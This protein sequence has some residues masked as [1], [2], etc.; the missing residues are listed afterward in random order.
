VNPKSSRNHQLDNSIFWSKLV[1]S[2]GQ[3]HLVT[4]QIAKEWLEQ[5]FGE[6]VVSIKQVE[7]EI[8]L[9][10]CLHLGDLADEVQ[11]R[12]LNQAHRCLQNA[13]SY[14]AK[15]LC[16]RLFEKH[17]KYQL[18]EYTSSDDLIMRIVDG[19]GNV[20]DSSLLA[21]ILKDFKP[22]QSCLAQRSYTIIK[23]YLQDEGVLDFSSDWKNLC[24]ITTNQLIRI[25]EYYQLTPDEVEYRCDIH[26]AFLSVYHE[27]RRRY[28]EDRVVRG[29]RKS[30]K[31]MPDPTDEQ[32]DRILDLIRQ[33]QDCLRHLPK[34]I[35]DLLKSYEQNKIDLKRLL[36]EKLKETSNLVRYKDND[37]FVNSFSHSRY[38]DKSG[39]ESRSTLQPASSSSPTLKDDPDV[40][41]L[42]LRSTRQAIQSILSRRLSCQSTGEKSHLCMRV[43]QLIYCENLSLEEIPGF[44]EERL[45]ESAN[46]WLRDQPSITRF[47]HKFF[48]LGTQRRQQEGQ[49]CNKGN[50]KKCF[51]TE[52]VYEVI[53]EISS[54]P[55]FHK[56][57][58]L[59]S[60]SLE[61]LKKFEL[62]IKDFLEDSIATYPSD[63]FPP[64]Q[65]NLR[66]KKPPKVFDYLVCQFV[67]H[68]LENR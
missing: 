24:Y 25:L 42:L 67:C 63:E 17:R 9:M 34:D 26:N 27:E 11:A 66:R 10:R 62:K 12:D 13:I 23:Q 53:R 39:S 40:R 28:Q 55:I 36:L 18:S 43:L 21:K 58:S 14:I 44:I 5:Q 2:A 52:V 31:T 51:L 47:L 16:K 45:F 7:I 19:R 8:H 38:S 20:V 3:Y 56:S 4:D 30:S 50:Y 48:G 37:V 15:Q 6:A 29:L 41:N 33:S 22:E 60:D 57:G 1:R 65:C 54:L 35:Q 49:P 59:D 32:L 61:K 46:I 68:Y 64:H